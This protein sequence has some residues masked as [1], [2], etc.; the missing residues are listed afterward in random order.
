MGRRHWEGGQLNLLTRR[1]LSSQ[2]Y[3]LT[4]PT[5][6]ARSGV[7]RSSDTELIDHRNCWCRTGQ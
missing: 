1:R 3:Y 6:C 2:V 4:Q 7:E 5:S